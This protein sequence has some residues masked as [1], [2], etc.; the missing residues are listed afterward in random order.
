MEKE[1]T[2][3]KAYAMILNVEHELNKQGIHYVGADL[4]NE[5]AMMFKTMPR[6][7]FDNNGQNTNSNQGPGQKRD[8]R[9]CTICNWN[10]HDQQ[11]KN[12]NPQ[13]QSWTGYQPKQQQQVNLAKVEFAGMLS[14]DLSMTCNIS[15]DWICGNG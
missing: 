6:K 11:G 3:A 4:F 8:N 12:R 7:D 14:L 9:Y 1:M 5:S 15:R 10:N 13:N 2:V